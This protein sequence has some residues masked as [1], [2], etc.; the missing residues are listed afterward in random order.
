MGFQGVSVMAD[1]KKIVALTAENIKRL[2]VVHIE[3]DGNTILIGGR[4]AQGKSSVLDSILY[5]MGGA[6]S[7]PDKP[8]RNGQESAEIEIDLG[9][10]VVKR[11]ITKSGSTVTVK[12]K[13]GA[14]Y[15]SP[16]K[17]LDGLY[18]KLS[19]DPLAFASMKPAD[20]TKALMALLGIDTSA[21]DKQHDKLYEE[22]T[23][24]NR[25]LKEAEGDLDR[26][27]EILIE[28]PATRPEVSE[29]S[30]RL[31]AAIETNA[32]L[33]RESEKI[34]SLKADIA[35]R[36]GE[37]ETLEGSLRCTKED[38]SEELDV[39]SRTIDSTREHDRLRHLREL[40]ELTARHTRENNDREQRFEA[41]CNRT[42]QAAQEREISLLNQVA[43]LKA[44]NER[45]AALLGGESDNERI[46][47]AAIRE[48]LAKASELQHAFDVSEDWKQKQLKY[49]NRLEESQELT[50]EME[51][52]KDRKRKIL[53]EANYPIPGLAVSEDGTVLF[54]GVPL[55]QASRAQQ[56]RTSVA[57]GI[58]MNP[59]LKVLLIRDGS[60]LDEDNLKLVADMAT[61][62]DAQIWI[63][64]VGDKDESAIIIEDGHIRESVPDPVAAIVDAVK[65]S[66]PVAT[67]EPLAET[68]PKRTRK[69][70]VSAEQPA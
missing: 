17:V 51:A 42:R 20:Q 31:E 6:S 19:F 22:R 44:A 53:A 29:I 68:K 43:S 47:V 36:N 14:S 30:Q 7:F 5:A 59:K 21:L 26:C 55:S 46:D 35:E 39:L 38:L 41:D 8:I 56:I 4:N 25:L 27:E 23:G 1:S 24:V 9:D 48:E 10:I 3:P 64:R 62:H 34:E 52:I 61:E 32:A 67:E 58:A 49:D 33:D 28:V 15:S 12:T 60:L 16:Q 63:E 70:T 69:K 11:K 66:E 37:I 50:D 57:I 13:D 54:D 40:E 45:D 18:S 2:S 65:T